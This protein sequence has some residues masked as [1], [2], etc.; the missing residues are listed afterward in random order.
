[1]PDSIRDFFRGG[2]RCGGHDSGVNRAKHR[3][4]R[5]ALWQVTG[6]ALRGQ[7]TGD[8]GLVYIASPF[9][10]KLTGHE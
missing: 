7:A 10:G 8:L 1:M 5:A 9:P 4:C 6:R 3:T 2:K